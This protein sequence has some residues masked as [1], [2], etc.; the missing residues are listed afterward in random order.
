MFTDKTI[1]MACI[2]HTRAVALAKET[3]GKIAFTWAGGVLCPGVWVVPKGN[4]GGIDA[5][6]LIAHMQDP[7]RQIEFT[8]LQRVGPVNPVATAGHAEG[9]ARLRPDAARTIWRSR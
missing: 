9:P 2:W 8:N 4:P 1:S 3:E 6:N 7:G 5:F